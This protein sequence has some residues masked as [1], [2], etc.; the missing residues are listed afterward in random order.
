[1]GVKDN[2]QTVSIN[3]CYFW[4]VSVTNEPSHLDSHVNCGPGNPQPSP[5][6]LPGKFPGQRSLVGYRSWG[7]K[8][9]GTTKAPSVHMKCG[10][11][12]PGIFIRFTTQI[13]RYLKKKKLL[14][15]HTNVIYN[16]RHLR[17]HLSSCQLQGTLKIN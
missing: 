7:H 15:H 11:F 6:S 5:A 16:N 17:N 10:G 9:L 13:H 2:P 4:I 12:S 14:S 1:M 3:K 8:E